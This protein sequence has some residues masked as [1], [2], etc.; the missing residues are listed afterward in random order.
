MIFVNED[1][2][3]KCEPLTAD[4]HPLPQLSLR[5]LLHQGELRPACADVSR[6]QLQEGQR[7]LQRVYSQVRETEDSTLEY[8]M[9]WGV[10]NIEAVP[11]PVE[12]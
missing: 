2:H 4:L 3:L 5:H 7:R 1:T 9:R 11:D 12:T 8:V 6:V 10:W